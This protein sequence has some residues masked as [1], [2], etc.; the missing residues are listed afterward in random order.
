MKR[1]EA[2]SGNQTRI[3][4]DIES[5]LRRLEDNQRPTGPKYESSREREWQVPGRP[6]FMVTQDLSFQYGHAGRGTF[7]CI[8]VWF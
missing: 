5:R 1:V 2:Q 7:C 8:T 4:M 3:L 6:D